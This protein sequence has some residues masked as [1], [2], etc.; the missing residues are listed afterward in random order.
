LVAPQELTEVHIV[1]LLGLIFIRAEGFH[2]AIK[3]ALH[4]FQSSFLSIKCDFDQYARTGSI[5]LGL[6]E[7]SNGIM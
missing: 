2:Q 3:G 5:V 6:H 1:A 7:L 4:R